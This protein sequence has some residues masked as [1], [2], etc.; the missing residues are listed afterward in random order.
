M[1]HRIA[2]WAAILVP[3]LTLIVVLVSE[4]RGLHARRDEEWALY[5]TIPQ[6]F[7]Q[8]A[9]NKKCRLELE[10]VCLTRAAGINDDLLQIGAVYSYSA[11]SEEDLRSAFFPDVDIPEFGS[12]KVNNHHY[13]LRLLS[14]NPV[15]VVGRN[16]NVE[17][18]V[19]I[20]R[21]SNSTSI[22]DRL[23]RL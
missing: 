14:V 17:G 16:L 5:G 10:L 4:F 9:A 12:E 22:A 2:V 15:R 13:T 6:N 3:T 8:L 19:H 1:K 11:S 7:E 21:D 20:Y 18:F 23:D